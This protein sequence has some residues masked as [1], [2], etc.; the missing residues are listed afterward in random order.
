MKKTIALLVLLFPLLTIAQITFQQGY[1]IQNGVKTE[2]L[3]KNQAW[4]NNPVSIEYKI[5]E[6][7]AP[8]M[9][10]I[11]EISEFS[12]NDAYKYIRFTVNIDRSAT[13]LDKLSNSKEPE[14]SK[15]TLFLNV[16]V[17]GK[18]NLYQYEDGNLIKYFFSTGDHTQAEQLV[19]KEYIKETAVAQNNMFRQQLYSLMKGDSN[20]MEK[21]K[22]LKYSK[23]TLLKLFLDYNGTNGQ[24]VTDHTEK[25]NKGSINLK[26][27]PGVSFNSLSFDINSSDNRFD[28]GGDTTY[29]IGAELEYILPF[30]NNKWSIFLDPNYQTYAV[31]GQ[32]GNQKF[33]V[34]YKY[35]ELPIGVRHFMFLNQNSK[36]FVDGT[37]SLGFALGDSNIEYGYRNLAIEKNSTIAFGAGF[38]YKQYSIE[39]RYSVTRN[40]LDYVNLAANYKSTSIILGYKLF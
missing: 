31:S 29:R 13:A 39:A 14:W 32:N 34:D 10:T 3:I 9:K 4:K 37:Y 36:F 28:F 16:L 19:F 33:K 35:I 38:S 7:D 27:T 26:I 22:K 11:R 12:V 17:D 30:N 25:Q 15:E 8:K 6:A 40:I 20:D 1:F 21:F 18:A 2:C 5:N 23:D 24:K